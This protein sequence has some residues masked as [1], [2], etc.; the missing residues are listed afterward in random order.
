MPSPSPSFSSTTSF[1][2]SL[3]LA[4]LTRPG[5]GN[6]L[7]SDPLLK[8]LTPLT[9]LLEL[10]DVL[11]ADGGT[12]WKADEA[13]ELAEM[14]ADGW[15]RG[16]ETVFARRNESVSGAGGPVA[17]AV[18]ELPADVDDGGEAACEKEFVDG[19][20]GW[21]MGA[22]GAGDMG[23]ALGGGG[24][25]QGEEILL[26][27][28]NGGKRECGGEAVRTR[29]VV[30]V[31]GWILLAGETLEKKRWRNKR[32]TATTTAAWPSF[33]RHGIA[34][35]PRHYGH[36]YSSIH[37]ITASKRENKPQTLGPRRE[38]GVKRKRYKDASDEQDKVQLDL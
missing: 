8:R 32:R 5:S 12:P 30:H 2:T 17:A 37:Q 28:G 13:A 1:A 6:A 3:P 22:T 23:D 36:N 33:H 27:R 4:L 19:P 29:S 11:A 15:W 21:R 38:N 9:P 20:R 18:P 14:D 26:L 31:L 16:L 10:A 7:D 24:D 25:E 34:L 35:P